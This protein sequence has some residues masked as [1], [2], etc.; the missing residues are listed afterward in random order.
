MGRVQC[1]DEIFL[2]RFISKKKKRKRKKEKKEKRK[3]LFLLLVRFM[4]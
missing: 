2:K 3:V 1:S 4:F